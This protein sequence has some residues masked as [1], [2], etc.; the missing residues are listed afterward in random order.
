MYRNSSQVRRTDQVHVIEDD[1]AAQTDRR[2]PP[3]LRTV[4]EEGPPAIAVYRAIYESVRRIQNSVPG[5]NVSTLASLL[6]RIGFILGQDVS[7]GLLELDSRPH[8]DITNTGNTIRFKVDRVVGRLIFGTQN[9]DLIALENK[10]FVVGQGPQIYEQ[11]RTEHLRIIEL[12]KRYLEALFAEKI[13]Q[14]ERRAKMRGSKPTVPMPD[15]PAMASLATSPDKETAQ[16]I[17]ALLNE[18]GFNGQ[19]IDMI[20]VIAESTSHI[21]I[22][23]HGLRFNH[24]QGNLIITKK[25]RVQ[26]MAKGQA[27]HNMGNLAEQ[28]VFVTQYLQAF[29]QHVCTPS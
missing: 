26:F 12:T 25:G 5:D 22:L 24:P 10:Q 27:P 9:Q 14:T 13:T 1:P 16:K 7:N 3:R 21:D 19:F 28:Q 6:E 15:L 4:A 23:P 18:H 29:E 2:K 8:L 17:W 11:L 20:P